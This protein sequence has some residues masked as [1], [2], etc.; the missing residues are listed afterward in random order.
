MKN[1]DKLVHSFLCDES[2]QDM[3]E[4]ALVAALIGLAAV[5]SI[6]GLATHISSAFTAIGT[7]VTA[8]I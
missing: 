5:V 7:S 1:F 3:I 2:A 8:D 4:Y 6:K